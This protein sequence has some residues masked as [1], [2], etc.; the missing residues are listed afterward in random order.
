MR[1]V[2]RIYEEPESPKEGAPVFRIYDEPE[3][4]N[5]AYAQHV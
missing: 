5:E 4:P 3:S 1:G 2:F